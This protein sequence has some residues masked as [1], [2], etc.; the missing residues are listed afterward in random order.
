MKKTT[1]LLLSLFLLVCP[2]LFAC[3]REARLPYPYEELKAGR[4]P[5]PLDSSLIR[6]VWSDVYLLTDKE[7][8]ELIRL[9]NGSV[10]QN[11]DGATTPDFSYRI[12]FTDGSMLSLSENG[13][14]GVIAI[15]ITDENGTY[16]P[17]PTDAVEYP[18]IAGEALFAYLRD[19]APVVQARAETAQ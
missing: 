12:F 10:V 16:A 15:Y 18:S 1:A 19:L 3:A 5:P 4:T 8:D 9:Y 7:I 17:N 14:C 11:S 6:S 13:A 2:L